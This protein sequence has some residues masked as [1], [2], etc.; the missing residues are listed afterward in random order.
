MRKN[1]KKK[2]LHLGLERKEKMNFVQFLMFV[3]LI[4]CK[5]VERKGQQ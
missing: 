2:F 3:L 4:S 5:K 1:N